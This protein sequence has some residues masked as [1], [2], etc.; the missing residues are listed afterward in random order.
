[1]A[2]IRSQLSYIQ[3]RDIRIECG[4]NISIQSA[5][6]SKRRQSDLRQRNYFLY[7]CVPG[8]AE[9]LMKKLLHSHGIVS[10]KK[11]VAVGHFTV[12]YAHS[13]NVC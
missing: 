11:Y 10:R 4:G 3:V 7:C 9:T 6:K 5:N 2:H 1:M 8:I 13:C 12:Y